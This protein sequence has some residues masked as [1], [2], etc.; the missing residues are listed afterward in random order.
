[1]L[2]PPPP[3]GGQKNAVAK[4][5]KAWTGLSAL[6]LLMQLNGRGFDDDR[7]GEKAG[8]SE[9]A[10]YGGLLV[11]SMMACVSRRLPPSGVGAKHKGVAGMDGIVG[12][13]TAGVKDIGRSCSPPQ[14]PPA[15]SR[16]DHAASA[17]VVVE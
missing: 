14:L 6:R 16:R 13:R 4:A 10:G 1:M 8:D 12:R 7:C 5:D 2:G 11:T 15:H 3:A 9:A 17:G